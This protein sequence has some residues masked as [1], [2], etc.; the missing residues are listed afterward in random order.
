MI[1]SRPAPSVVYLSTGSPLSH[2]YI[3]IYYNCSLIDWMIAF[4]GRRGFWTLVTTCDHIQPESNWRTWTFAIHHQINTG[5]HTYMQ[6]PITLFLQPLWVP[7]MC[8][9]HWKIFLLLWQSQ[10]CLVSFCVVGCALD[11][12]AAAAAVASAVSRRNRGTRHRGTRYSEEQQ[13]QNS[14]LS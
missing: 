3:F 5:F 12:T 7:N 1:F 10:C 6:D 14:A 9:C 2:M 4:S 13:R 8:H 11:D